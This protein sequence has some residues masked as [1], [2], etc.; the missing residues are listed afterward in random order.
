MGMLIRRAVEDDLPMHKPLPF[1]VYDENSRLL[2]KQGFV[3]TIPGFPQRLLQRGCYVEDASGSSESLDK[4][5]AEVPRE[6]IVTDKNSRS[7]VFYKRRSGI[8]VFLRAGEFLIS[9][10]RIHKLLHEAPSGRVVLQ[11]Y[12]RER[13]KELLKLMEEDR[14]AVFAAAYLTSDARDSRANQQ[15][16]GAVVAILMAPQCG[17]SEDQ[18][19]SLICAA[20]TRDAAL[21]MIDKSHATVRKLSESAMATVREHPVAAVKLLLQ[22]GV[23]DRNWLTYVVEHH[24]RPDGN[25]YPHGKKESNLQFA[26]L[27]LGLADTYA[28]MVLSNLRRPGIFPANA[29]KEIYLGKGHQYQERQVVLLLKILTRFPAGTLVALVNGEIGVVRNPSPNQAQPQ[30]YSL[31]DVEGMLRSSPVVRDSSLSEFEISGCI[32]PEKCKSAELVLRR[33][34]H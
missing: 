12:V 13:A 25:G 3:I 15:L 30:V 27:L 5:E 24:E 22:H 1:S 10:R 6:V 20:L 16:L 32:A 33:I 7:E 19:L 4:S 17:L 23:N 9:I 11:D 34:W 8:P 28:G 14:D 18:Q 29:L 31:Y 2:L 26:S 21:H